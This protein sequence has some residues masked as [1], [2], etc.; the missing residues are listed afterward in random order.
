MNSFRHGFRRSVPRRLLTGTPLMILLVLLAGPAPA[1]D[2]C[3][4]GRELYEAGDPTGARAAYQE[5]LTAG[6]EVPGVLLP[7][8][9]LNLEADDF[10]AAADLAARAVAVAPEDP[11]ARYW[12][13]RALLRSE[14]ADEAK[15]QWEQGLMYSVEHVGIL[16]G[17]ARLSL[18]TG[19]TAKA[20]NLFTQLQ[21]QG[22][23]APWLHRLLA[24]IAAGKGLWD[25]SLIHLEQVIGSTEMTADDLILAS[26][27]ALVAR[28][29]DKALDYG[30]RAVALAPTARTLGGLGEAFFAV[31][32]VDS[33]IV[34]LRRA[35]VEPEATHRYRF[36]LANAL[37]VA[38]LF[39]E[40]GDEFRTYLVEAPEDPVGHFNY[41]VHLDKGGRSEEALAVLARAV[42]LDPDMLTAYVVRAQ[43]YEGQGRWDEAL[44]AV[45]ALRERD[46]G[47]AAELREW[48]RRLA[49]LQTASA[50]AASTGKVHLLYM[51][52]GDDDVLAR[53]REELAQGV[54]FADVTMRYSGG[55]AAARGGDI[56]WIRP[57]E[58]VEPLRGAIEILSANEISPPV[59][60]GGLY[61]IFKR[62]P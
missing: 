30:R 5:C 2:E 16:E 46:P 38:G 62:V 45:E 54:D 48:S 52:L 20:Y 10:V 35:V 13:G 8:S 11:E 60:S 17:M 1:E 55:P 12:Y 22:V 58:M 32:Q 57:E 49:S 26:E 50:E 7:L 23:D 21:R 28:H 42:E 47:N 29:G 14:R 33:A 36:N 44:Q 39:T 6:M 18:A 41:G 61:H 3:P 56:G 59:E 51:V 15:A 4:R 31:D 43:I 37:E 25:Q 53:V 9:I 40:A 19:E 24:E 34:Y 27:L